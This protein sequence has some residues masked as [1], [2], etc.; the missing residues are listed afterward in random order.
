MN[1]QI[2]EIEINGIKYVPK[3]N[4]DRCNTIAAPKKNMV[5]VR[6]ESAGC[7]FGE[8]KSCEPDKGVAVLTNARRLWYWSG[9]SSLSQLAV[10]GT[11]K[12]GECKF[13]ASVSEI[14]L[15]KVIEIIQ[16]S[17]AAVDSI[18]RVAIWKS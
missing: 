2:N 11:G 16:C 17:Q 3:E 12:P 1:Q 18:N 14:A 5:I 4:P 13:P 10:D 9:A 7:F 15:A 8:L 6:C